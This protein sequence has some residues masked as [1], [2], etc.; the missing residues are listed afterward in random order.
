M[1]RWRV[2]VVDPMRPAI[3][4]ATGRAAG[5]AE[6]Y[7]LYRELAAWWPLISPPVE[8]AEDAATI[9][10]V[11]GAAKTPVRTVLDLGSGGGHVAWYLKKDRSMTLVDRSAEMLEVSAQ[12]NPDCVH[13]QG[14]MRTARLGQE[15]DAVLVHDAVDY[16][17]DQDDLSLVI[18][19]AFAHCRPRGLAVFAPDHTG[20]TFRPGTGSG[21]GNDGTGRQATFRE[22]RSD[23]DPGDD[24]ILA[25]YEFT[26]RERDGTV[27][28]VR[29]AHRLGSFHQATWLRL[30]TG[31][32]FEARARPGVKAGGSRPSRALFVGHKPA[33]P[34]VLPR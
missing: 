34:D 12:L 1:A 15:F 26:L 31:A 20:D 18:Q 7:S 30:L 19:T 9:D 4:P 11:F 17:T 5:T 3:S 8:Y 23:P 28:V 2:D 27:R 22:R 25:E 32:G 16:V 29:E 33:D 24:W 14:D 21:G 6:G 13:I 10:E